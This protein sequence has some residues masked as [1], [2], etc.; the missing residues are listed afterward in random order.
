M[1]ALAC[2]ISCDR[3]AQACPGSPRHARS[4][5]P[6]WAADRLPVPGRDVSAA[7]THSRAPLHLRC[8][9]TR[10]TPASSATRPAAPRRASDPIGVVARPVLAWRTVQAVVDE[11]IPAA[12]LVRPWRRSRIRRR[13]GDPMTN[14]Q[15]VGGRREPCRMARLA[16]RKSA[17]VFPQQRKESTGHARIE[18]QR[19]RQLHQDRTALV[20]QASRLLEESCEQL[21]RAPQLL[22][23]GDRARHLHREQEVGRRRRGPPRIRGDRVRTMKRGIDL[24]AAQDRRVALQVRAVTREMMAG[25]PGNAPARRTNEGSLP[26][27][28]DLGHELSRPAPLKALQSEQQSRCRRACAGDQ[29]RREPV[30]AFG[31]QSSSFVERA[32][33]SR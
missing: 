12:G 15:G 29:L 31:L 26:A 22:V 28:G 2:L 3:A 5:N 30:S 21:A 14:Q 6:R 9:R 11:T 16:H 33:D 13:A 25:R 17:I 20:A 19:R 8:C 23:V 18:R 1:A 27:A 10:T 7:P 24:G 32:F 4:P